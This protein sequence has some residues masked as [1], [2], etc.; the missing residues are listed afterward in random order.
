MRRPAPPQAHQY[1][2]VHQE[3]HLPSLQQDCLKRTL[4]ATCVRRVFLSR[5]MLRL[6][7]DLADLAVLTRALLILSPDSPNLIKSVHRHRC[8]ISFPP[9]KG[10]LVPD[11]VTY[12]QKWI[13]KVTKKGYNTWCLRG[14]PPRPPCRPPASP[15]RLALRPPHRTSPAW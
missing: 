15:Q 2:Q 7:V 8:K 12:N 4:V 1:Q 6:K 3:E 13:F 14:W 10:S 5:R 9:K 11:G